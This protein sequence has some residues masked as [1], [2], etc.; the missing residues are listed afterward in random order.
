VC[1]GS[2]E[3]GGEDA[4]VVEAEP[5]HFLG[6]GEDAEAV[7]PSVEEDLPHLESISEEADLVDS[8]H[9]N[10]E[11][12]QYINTTCQQWNKSAVILPNT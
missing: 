8:V 5:V 12:Y 3:G 4:D 11:L 7:P 2:G 1:G 6:G 10:I 9:W